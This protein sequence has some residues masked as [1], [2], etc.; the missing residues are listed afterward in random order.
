MYFLFYIELRRKNTG[1]HLVVKIIK[2]TSSSNETTLP[3][4]FWDEFREH[5][6]AAAW[7]CRGMY[8]SLIIVML[9]YITTVYWIPNQSW[10]AQSCLSLYFRAFFQ[11]DAEEILHEYIYI[12]EAGFNKQ[13]HHVQHVSFQRSVDS[14][15]VSTPSTFYSIV[16]STIFSISKP[17]QSISQH[18]GG[19]FM[20][21]DPRL[22]CPSFR[23]VTKLTPHLC[24]D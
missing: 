15:L 3:S 13:I 6:T 2:K 14:Q 21:S 4:A 24:K 18:G 8:S 11:T 23:P 5:Q 10:T 17:N 20:I 19:R 7:V 9:H 22:R 12:D 16:P 1:M